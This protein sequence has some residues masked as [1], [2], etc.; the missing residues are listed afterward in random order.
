LDPLV[1]HLEDKH[2]NLVVDFE[3]GVQPYFVLHASTKSD[4]QV[5]IAILYKIFFIV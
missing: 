4:R 5:R 1:Q 2:S 3:H